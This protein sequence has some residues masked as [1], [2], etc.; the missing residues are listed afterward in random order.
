MDSLDMWWCGSECWVLSFSIHDS[1]LKTRHRSHSE[2]KVHE[3]EV[4][5]NVELWVLGCL[6]TGIQETIHNSALTTYTWDSDQRKEDL[7]HT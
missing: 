6:K 2:N 1:T 3:E 5:L 4:V 7:L